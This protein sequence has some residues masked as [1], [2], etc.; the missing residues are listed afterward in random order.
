MKFYRWLDANGWQWVTAWAAAAFLAVCLTN[1]CTPA[2]QA[3]ITKVEQTILTDLEN[4]TVLSDI[5]AAVRALVPQGADV[6]VII[7]DAITL[8]HDLGIIPANVLPVALDMQ[9]KLAVKLQAKGT[10]K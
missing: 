3:D 7:N 2:Q 1:S 4:G 6:D 5:E 10:S 9:S 8:M